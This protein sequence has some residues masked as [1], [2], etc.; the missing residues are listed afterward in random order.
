[1]RIARPLIVAAAVAAG[2]WQSAAG[3]ETPPGDADAADLI[4]TGGEIKTP[5][6]WADALAIR[7][8]IIMAVGG[9]ATI[10][11][12]RGPKTQVLML[13]GGAVLPGLFDVHVHP[14]F[15]GLSERECKIAQ[16][17]TLAETQ[18]GLRACASKT[19]AGE[20]V[21]GG[22]WDASALGQVPNR[23]ALDAAIPDHPAL[24]DDTSGHSSWANSKALAIAGI[25]RKTPNPENGIIERDNSGEPT[26]IL[27]ESA[28]DLVKTHIPKPT[29]QAARAALEWAL[30]NMLSFGITSYT[31]AAVGFSAGAD[32][33]LKTYAALA[34][35][36][37]LKQRTILCITWAPGS[38]ESESAIRTRN[39]YARDRL[40][41][42]C[43]KIFLDGVPT[44][45]HTAAM[46]EPYVGPLKG[47]QDEAARMGMLLVKQ[48]TLDAAVTRFDNMG[49]TVK[50]HAA[51]DAAVRAGLNAIAAARKANG[52]SAQMHNVGHCTFVAKSDV[53]RARAIGATFEV[54]PYLWA[55]SPT[56]DDITTA[57]GDEVIQR[58]WPVRELVDSGAL[59]VPGSDWSVVPSVNPWPAIEALVTR[60]LPGGS[61]KSFGKGESITLPE[62]IDLF[63]VN[64]AKQA[65]LSDKVGRI[66]AGMLAD[67]IVLDQNPYRVPITRIHD[68]KVKMTFIGG[69]KVFDAVKRPD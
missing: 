53:A 25:T 68:T 54:S 34:D 40:S 18:R 58:V 37:V 20:W 6:G 63:T 65:R 24:I 43:V 38:D 45:S 19:E 13:N 52:F 35:A 36:G 27:R 66:E 10:N 8:G 26:G 57:V 1:M 47:R 29:A 21:I 50:F 2:A 44:D 22:Q 56:S 11:A 5:S 4:M 39:R 67:V 17:S 62:A 3:T 64:S 69:E 48:D 9:A 14:L 30:S 23:A 31:E 55:P 16:G 28:A 41:T 15:A 60:E 59:V 7:G 61:H 12:L 42:D 46:L 32:L 33:E 49:L 51:G